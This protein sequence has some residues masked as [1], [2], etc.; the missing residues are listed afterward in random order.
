MLLVINRVCFL[1]GQKYGVGE[2]ETVKPRKLF[3]PS[4]LLFDINS[5]SIERN[6]RS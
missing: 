4:L 2:V 1:G 6:H 3:P 5:P